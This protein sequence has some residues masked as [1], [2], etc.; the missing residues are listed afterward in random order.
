MSI[1]Y[2]TFFFYKTTENTKDTECSIF[3][4]LKV[5]FKFNFRNIF[6]VFSDF[7]NTL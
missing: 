6:G 2:F 3:L 4:L 7:V 1:L 5:S